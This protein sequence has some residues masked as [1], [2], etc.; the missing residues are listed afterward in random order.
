MSFAGAADVHRTSSQSGFSVLEVI[1]AMAVLSMALIPLLSFQSQLGAGAA[2]LEH[3]SQVTIARTVAQ[4]YAS[5]INPAI[6]PQ[7]RLTIGA[8]WTLA[9]DSVPAGPV[10]RARWG[11]GVSSRHTSQLF[12]LT[13][14]LQ[15]STGRQHIITQTVL[16]VS[17]LFP[18]DG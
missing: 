14:R 10:Q 6:I 15:N 7:G 1:A 8:G 2:R 9:W 16:G 5:L 18:A 3:Q 12:T 11:L 17:E 4:D 13:L